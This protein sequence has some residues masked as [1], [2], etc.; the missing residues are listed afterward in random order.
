MAKKMSEKQK[1]Y[2]FREQEYKRTIQQIIEDIDK[3]SCK[4]LAE[5]KEP[6]EDEKQFKA[7]KLKLLQE[8]EL[9]NNDPENIEV[10]ARTQQARLPNAKEVNKIHTDLKAI[11]D[12]IEHIAD[13][14]KKRLL[15][16]R[17]TLYKKLA[18][19]L[20]DYKE[21][22]EQENDKRRK[23]EKDKEDNE[24]NLVKRL[25]LMTE[26]AEKTDKDN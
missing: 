26:I 25:K 5:V 13:E 11:H 16:D 19:E 2:I 15:N 7:I 14:T 10:E 12:E 6:T 9:N 20:Q 24:D 1:E 23:N 21:E 3:R 4:P 17:N 8:S 18:K 22:L